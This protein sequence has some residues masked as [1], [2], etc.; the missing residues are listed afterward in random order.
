M[1]K[2]NQ[3]FECTIT[4]TTNTG[5]GVAHIEGTTVFVQNAAEGDVCSVRIIKTAKDYSVARIETLNTPSPF[6]VQN[7]CKSYNVCGGC[8]FRHISYSREKDIK[9]GFVKKAFGKFGLDIEVAPLISGNEYCYRNKV[10]YPAA[11]DKNGRLFFGFFSE[12]SHRAINVDCCLIENPVFKPVKAAVTEIL[13]RHRL[14][15]YNQSAG[16]GEIRH[17][18]LRA[19]SDNRVSV[20]IVTSCI[21]LSSER[22]ITQE[23]TERLSSVQSVFFNVNLEKTNVVLGNSTRLS[24]GEALL[25]DTLCGRSF[26]ISPMSFYQINREMAEKLYFRAKELADCV[27]GDVVLDLYCGIGSI[28]ISVCGP[29]NKLF[30]VE[31]VND[32]VEN[33]RNNAR[34]NGLSQSSVFVCADA[35]EGVRQC[36][37]VYGTP[38]VIIVDPPRKGIGDS[39]I[40]TI[41]QSGTKKAV[42]ISC[43]PA[44]M[45]R[46]IKKF[47]SMGWTVGTVYPFDLFPRTEHVESVVL[48]LRVD[49]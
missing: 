40:E 8:V 10:M 26:G 4:D 31:I 27:A 20:C 2:K 19:S 46:D 48:M 18:F 47:V 21:S 39:V 3:I 41:N 36:K 17:L 49:K 28:G 15:A 24:G 35:E 29:E 22:E 16:K 7:D 33:A 43:N 30:G 12:Y 11:T 25:Y 37:A 23:I 6:R 5:H 32:A 9:Y 14:S 44:T 13:N 1:L 42:Y 45:A 34:L 38:D